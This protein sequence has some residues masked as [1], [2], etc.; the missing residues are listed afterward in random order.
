MALVII[1]R[2]A[3]VVQLREDALYLITDMKISPSIF[4][5]YDI[6]GA[7]PHEIDEAVA[8]K[9]GAGA[10]QF[11][12][13][14]YHIEAPK[15]LV[16]RDIRASSPRLMDALVKGLLEA[17]ANVLDGG[18]GTTPFFYYV[19]DKIRPDGGIMVTASHS[20]P[21]FNGFKVQDRALRAVSLDSGLKT[22]AA[23][24]KKAGIKKAKKMGLFKKIPDCQKEY[25]AF[26]ADGISIS[27]P[28]RAVVDAAGGA[29]TL[30]LPQ[31]LHLF[32][33]IHYAPLFFEP[34]GMF[35]RHSPNPLLPEAQQFVRNE[36]KKGGYHFGVVFD[37]D[38]DRVLFFD[39]RGSVLR[40]DFVFALLA[41][42]ELKKEKNATFVLTLNTSKGVREYIKERGGKIILSPQ[43]YPY[44]QKRMRR[45]KAVGG[46]ELSGHYHLK[47]TFYRDSTLAPFLSM[48]E[49]LSE[50]KEPLSKLIQQVERYV[51]SEEISFPVV[52]KQKVIAKIKNYFSKTKGAKLSY[53]D[54]VT[55]EFPDWWFNVRAA[56]TED[57]VRMSIEAVNKELYQ[58]KRKEIERLLASDN[59]KKQ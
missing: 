18:I 57:V 30:F 38:S 21:K 31:L 15:I 39:E 14:K 54:G 35:R 20:P 8:Q 43:G 25:I 7:Y 37:G 2:T 49:I 58:E 53:L 1:A 45:Y 6:R 44:L 41:A 51:T 9:I 36:L 33:N 29:E 52:Q 27:R 55:V 46:V 32:A 40:A 23:L 11:F 48:A 5:A 17:G 24:A 16:C 13:N 50:T 28:V 34:D 47:K 56:N 4:Q 19:L 3:A 42:E 10:A 59:K 26:L 12:K 22:I